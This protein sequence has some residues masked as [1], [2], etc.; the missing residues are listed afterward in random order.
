M[1]KKIDLLHGNLYSALLWF[2]LPFLAANLIQVLYGT[3]DLLVV[4]WYNSEAQI[5]AVSLGSQITQLLLSLITGLTM[6][7]TVLIAQYAGNGKDKDIKSSIATTFTLFLLLGILL[8]VVMLMLTPQLLSLIRTPQE[9]YRDACSYVYICSMGI[10]FSFGYNAVSAVLRGLGDSKSPLYFITIACLFNIVLDFLLVAGFHMGAAGA[11]IATTFFQV[12]SLLLSIIFLRKQKFS[13][14]FHLSSFHM[15]RDKALLLLKIGLPISLQEVISAVSFLCIAAIINGFGVAASAAAGICNKFEGFAMLPSTA[16]ASAISTIAAQNI[17]AGNW[18]RAGKA[19]WISVLFAFTASMI[20]F[21]WAGISSESILRIFKA[22]G[23]VITAGEQYLHYF[24]YD[25]LLVAFGFTMNGFFN[26]C[27]RTL[28]AMINGI[29]ASVCIRIPLV[30]ILSQY[31]SH[32]LTGIGLA[33]PA[34]TLV[35][36]IAGIIYYRRGKWKQA[37]LV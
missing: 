25:F 34:A 11:A 9:A 20:F 2:A 32:D 26:G 30:F 15:Q 23:A 7:S 3:V 4:G 37:L 33:I 29:A 36:V 24:R 5:S 8:T 14:D 18:K 28:F 6:G 21:V 1:Q 13:F 10:I 12:I 16:I 35:S 19:L 17:G 31:G 27:G 22:E